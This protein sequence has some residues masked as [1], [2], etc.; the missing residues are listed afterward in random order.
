M[1]P[2]R[3]GTDAPRHRHRPALRPNAPMDVPLTFCVPRDVLA[4][5]R[6]GARRDRRVRAS[7][8]LS[9][10]VA[11]EPADS[12]GRGPL[13]DRPRASGVSQRRGG[14]AVM[15]PDW[16]V[17]E[18]ITGLPVGAHVPVRV[19]SHPG[20]AY[21]SS[22]DDT[23][24]LL[25]HR[26][27]ISIVVPDFA[28]HD[29]D[30]ARVLGQRAVGRLHLARTRR[31]RDRAEVHR[32]RLTRASARSSAPARPGVKPADRLARH[33]VIRVADDASWARQ[34][35]AICLADLLGRLLPRL[36]FEVGRSAG[37][38]R[39]AARPADVAGAHATGAPAPCAHRPRGARRREI[40]LTVVVGPAPTATSSSTPTAGSAI[41]ANRGCPR[42]RRR[43][44]PIGPLAA[45]CRGAS[46]VVQQLLGDLLPA[47]T[48][49][50]DSYW[51]ALT[52]GPVDGPDAEN[53]RS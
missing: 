7:R 41:S 49:V 45:A 13:C 35:T 21:H 46:Q 37:R 25:S 48:R 34:V 4:E 2:L 20:D 50:T 33:V 26:G 47:T 19:H 9:L 11:R 6:R 39:T 16:A 44:N 5:T 3:E 15:I 36:A 32:C 30:L 18:L 38:R 28:R 43:T 14:L 31:R 22:T 23:N 29:P 53:P 10:W 1:G 52:L 12:G 40:A 27:A 8:A 51:S 24:R 42:R 17:S